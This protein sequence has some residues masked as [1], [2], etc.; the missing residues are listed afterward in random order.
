M[1]ISKMRL[2][3]LLNGGDRLMFES[4][5]HRWSFDHYGVTLWEIADGIKTTTIIPWHNIAET[6][7]TETNGR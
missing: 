7:A 3:I 5:N 6:T 1:A 2:V 4:T